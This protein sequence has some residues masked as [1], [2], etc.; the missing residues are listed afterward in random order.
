MIILS[1]LN[2]RWLII[3]LRSIWLQ[4]RWKN[5]EKVIKKWLA[6]NDSGKKLYLSS[7]Y[8]IIPVHIFSSHNMIKQVPPS[9]ISS[10]LL[11]YTMITVAQIKQELLLKH[12]VNEQAYIF[13]PASKYA[14]YNPAKKDKNGNVVV[15]Q[16]FPFIWLL[17]TISTSIAI[18]LALHQYLLP[19]QCIAIGGIIFLVNSVIYKKGP[20]PQ[21]LTVNKTGIT[22]DHQSYRWEDYI[23]L[24]LFFYAVN[25]EAR[26]THADIVL[27]WSS[28]EIAL[29]W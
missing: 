28:N 2:M 9:G 16:S 25:K 12:G 18:P 15:R 14:Y 24:Y 5:G 1:G 19:W 3:V 22:I 23:G 29:I 11:L 27:I 13:A 6:G 21:V 17:Q 4:S 7:T 10:W 20:K 8:E 26:S